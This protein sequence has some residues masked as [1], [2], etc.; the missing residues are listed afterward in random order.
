MPLTQFPC[1]LHILL[2]HTDC[3]SS[4]LKL[5]VGLEQDLRSFSFISVDIY[6][7][8]WLYLAKWTESYVRSW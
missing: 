8:R 4:P 2:Y 6:D 1:G 7:T 3:F 5:T